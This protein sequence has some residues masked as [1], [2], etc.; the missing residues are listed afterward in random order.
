MAYIKFLGI[1]VISRLLEGLD[2]AKIDRESADSTSFF[3][4][5][6][7]RYIAAILNQSP[8]NQIAISTHSE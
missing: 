7:H 6:W 4:I 8:E 5:T 3:E 2:R 1:F